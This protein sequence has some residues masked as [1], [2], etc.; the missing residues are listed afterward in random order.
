MTIRNQLKRRYRAMLVVA[1]AVP[2]LSVL[3]LSNSTPLNHTFRVSVVT[4]VL[5]ANLLLFLARF[6]CP[7]CRANISAVS[8]QVLFESGTCTCPHCG[9]DLNQSL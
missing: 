3:W 1:F 9:T 5:L 8:R 7:S 2:G 4:L 6:K